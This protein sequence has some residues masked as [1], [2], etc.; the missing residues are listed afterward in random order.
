MPKKA[1]LTAED[2]NARLLAE[3]DCTEA[4]AVV[5]DLILDHEDSW[6]QPTWSQIFSDKVDKLRKRKVR[7]GSLKREVQALAT[8]ST[9]GCVAGWV[10]Q[11]AGDRLVLSEYD[12]QVLREGGRV[13]VTDVITRGGKL[14][15][16]PDRGAELL[17]LDSLWLFEADRSLTEVLFALEE[18]AA[19]K[20]VSESR[21]G[22]IKAQ[23]WKPKRLR[24]KP[25]LGKKLV[26]YT[27]VARPAAK[28]AAKST[29]RS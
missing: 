12:I 24:P 8:C 17:C 13:S 2:F 18:L 29:S 16:I 1:G 6:N 26:E 28:V 9:T 23:G 10:T 22:A 27:K 20:P 15:A 21:T 4:A 3:S 19:G 5:H 7:Q 11:L 14:S 25:L